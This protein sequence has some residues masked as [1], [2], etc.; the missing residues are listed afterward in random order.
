M[1]GDWLVATSTSGGTGTLTLTNITGWPN[2]NNMLGSSATVV[3]DY[4]IRE[5]TDA[6]HATPKNFEKGVGSLNLSTMVL[7]RS[8]V[9]RSFDG[10]TYLPKVGGGGAPTQLSF[11]T[12][13][14]N[15]AVMCSLSS[16]SF[17]DMMP[18][19]S[20]QGTS[21]GFY[22]QGSFANF[23]GTAT[24]GIM[25][26]F[27]IRFVSRLPRVSSA[28]IRIAT[29]A[30]TS[31]TSALFFGLYEAAGAASGNPDIGNLIADFGN[32]SAIS[33]L[34]ATGIVTGTLTNPI[35]NPGWCWGGLLLTYNQ[36]ADNPAVVS[37][38]SIDS[39]GLASGFAFDSFVT[40]TGLSA[41][42]STG[43]GAGGTN[44]GQIPAVV[45]T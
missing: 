39:V 32:G 17:L 28:Q 43:S 7:T 38:T 3:V 1:F 20:Q 12:T 31:T 41:L 36:V 10:T 25:Y 33:T 22:I 42:P 24:S 4:Q 19:P 23:P 16:E 45:F 8:V 40:K 30:A 29:A 35:P 5:W 2:F 15:I 18:F 14:A 9:E 26:W 44:Q 13:A 34:A 11:G 6:T 37:Y 27:P 21:G